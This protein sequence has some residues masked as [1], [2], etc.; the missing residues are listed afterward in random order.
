MPPTLVTAVNGLSSASSRH[1]SAEAALNY[2]KLSIRKN[3]RK[4]LRCRRNHLLR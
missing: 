4:Q 1:A 2:S 3:Y